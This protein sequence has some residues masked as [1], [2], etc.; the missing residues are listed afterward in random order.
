[1]ANLLTRLLPREQSFFKM[2][3]DLTENYRIRPRP[4]DILKVVD[5]LSGGS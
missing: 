5:E 4:E 1:M 3:T 2:F